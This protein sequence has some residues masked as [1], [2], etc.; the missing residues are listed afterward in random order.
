MD[1]ILGAI[2]VGLVWNFEELKSTILI[3][4]TN[5]IQNRLSNNY[6]KNILNNMVYLTA[7]SGLLY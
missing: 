5:I 2:L 1:A 6:I 3:S 4:N 7:F